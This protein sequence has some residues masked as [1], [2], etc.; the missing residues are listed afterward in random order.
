MFFAVDA[1]DIRE[2]PVM[3]PPGRAKLGTMPVS[4]GSLRQEMMAIIGKRIAPPIAAQSTHVWAD[5]KTSN[6]SELLI[7][8]QNQES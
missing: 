2:T 4:T 8:A 1:A 5:D 3:F 7:A 6:L